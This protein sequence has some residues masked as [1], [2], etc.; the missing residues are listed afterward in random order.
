MG[1]GAVFTES[2]MARAVL[3]LNIVSSIDNLYKDNTWSRGS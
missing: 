1:D 2:A 3:R